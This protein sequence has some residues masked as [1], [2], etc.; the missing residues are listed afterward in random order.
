[1]RIG[2]DAVPFA[3]EQTGI[4]RY[5]SSVLQEMQ[6]LDPGT[7][8]LLYSPLPITVPMTKGNWR[9]RTVKNGPLRRPSVWMQTALPGLL[10]MD[11]VDAFWA[12][13]TNLPIWLKRWCFRVLTIHDLV[14]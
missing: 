8:F 2:I 10:A 6:I 14:P 5:L 13:P 3:Y 1:M 12:Q 9:V 11:K 4:G 7:E